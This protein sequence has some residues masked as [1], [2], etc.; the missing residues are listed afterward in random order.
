MQRARKDTTC[1][2]AL[3]PCGP[4]R[5]HVEK[6]SESEWRGERRR[7]GKFKLLSLSANLVSSTTPGV[8][9]GSSTLDQ[10]SFLHSCKQLVLHCRQQDASWGDSVGSSL[11]TG[12]PS[13]PRSI[14]H[15]LDGNVLELDLAEI[16]LLQLSSPL[17]LPAPRISFRRLLLTL[18]LA[19]ALALP[20]IPLAR[21]QQ[22]QAVQ[23]FLRHPGP[24]GQ[25]R[26]DEL[27]LRSLQESRPPEVQVEVLVPHRHRHR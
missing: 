19:L 8:S 24:G 22:L 18:A 15:E 11:L 21:G 3:T 27:L 26:P 9:R 12:K 10:A 20:P 5:S 14:V 13:I 17:R 7:V 16:H 1:P 2:N 6:E 23:H 25:D 4:G